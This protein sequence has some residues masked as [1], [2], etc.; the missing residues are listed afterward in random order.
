[1]AGVRASVRSQST[2]EQGWLQFACVECTQLVGIQIQ[3]QSKSGYWSLVLCR[4]LEFTPFY[5]GHW[6]VL[7]QTSLNINDNGK[8]RVVLSER[9]IAI[10]VLV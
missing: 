9:A 1:M 6:F 4:C 10:F 8:E 5:I 7:Y 3:K 2:Y